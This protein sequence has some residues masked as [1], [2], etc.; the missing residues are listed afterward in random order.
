ML[1]NEAMCNSFK[2]AFPGRDG[3]IW[4]RLRRLKPGRL[5]LEIADDGVGWRTGAGGRV[6]HGLDLMRLLAKQLHGELELGDRVG[7]GALVAVEMP[8]AIE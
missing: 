4:M 1:A 2:H 3:R 7:G 8:E 5:R 6:S